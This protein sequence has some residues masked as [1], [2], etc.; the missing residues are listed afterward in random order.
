[1]S[2]LLRRW[3]RKEESGE[4]VDHPVSLVV[5]DIWGEEEEEG[6]RG[7]VII[8]FLVAPSNSI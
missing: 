8:G 7:G 5:P 6:K 2:L 3:R 4:G 1:M